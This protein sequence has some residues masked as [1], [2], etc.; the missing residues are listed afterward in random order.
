MDRNTDFFGEEVGIF[1]NRSQLPTRTFTH[2]TSFNMG[3]LIPFYTDSDILPSMTIKN[4]TAVLIRMST[5]K[6]PI[7]DNIYLDTYY[8]KVPI[9]WIDPRF[10]QL[11]GENEDGA[12]TDNMTTYATPKIGFTRTENGIVKHNSILAYMGIP[13]GFGGSENNTMKIIRYPVNA[14]IRSYNYWFRDQNAIAPIKYIDTEGE[15]TFYHPNDNIDEVQST[16]RGGALLKAAKMH[17]YFTTALPQPQ[18]GEPISLPLGTTAPVTISG[19]GNVLG[20]DAYDSAGTKLHAGTASLTSHGDYK[21]IGYRAQAGYNPNGTNVGTGNLNA[22]P[23]GGQIRVTTD[24]NYSGLIGTANLTSAT[25]ATI[26]ALRL[27]AATQQILE[28]D[29]RYGTMYQNVIRGHFGV[30]SDLESLHI[31]E[32]LG[33]KRIPI[34]I[35]TVLNNTADGLGDTGAFSVSFD[36]NEDFTKSFTEHCV[37][38]GIA[39]VRQEHTYQQGISRM[40]TRSERLDYYWPEMAHIGNQPIYNYE[41]YAQGNDQDNEVFGYKEAWAE[42]KFKPSIVSGMMSSLY[43]QPL[44][45]WHLG[46]NY[47]SLPVYGKQFIEEDKQY[48]DRALEV[49]SGVS[50]QFIADFFITQEITAN[51][52]YHNYPG[53]HVL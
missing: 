12:W 37:V 35:E 51:M 19:N 15:I 14:Y 49:T 32:Y 21:S 48:L 34:N 8:F 1:A 38:I 40:W 11:M 31:P 53:M 45:A 4:T 3:E 44:D 39:V 30:T 23:W 16:I 43:D 24:T 36:V 7:M 29:A 25:A 10:K 27:A 20:I 13:Q 2:K 42:Y 17:D 33:G 5:P 26:N 52:P 50:D 9:Q 6:Y 47:S 18:K 22:L 46:D 28:G 41:L